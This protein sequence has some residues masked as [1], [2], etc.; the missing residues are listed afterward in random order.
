MSTCRI[1]GSTSVSGGHPFR[2]YTDFSTTLYDCNDCGCRFANRDEFIYERLHNTPS[3]YA[4]HRNL[5]VQAKSFFDR[6]D[7][8]GLSRYLRK[9]E[10]NRFILEHLE[11]AQNCNRVLEFGCSRGYLS[12]YAILLGKAFYGIDVSETALAAARADFGEY[13]HP[14]SKVDSFPDGYF[15]FIYHVGTIGCVNDPIGF[16]KRQIRLL[17][18]GGILLFNAPNLD[19]CHALGLEWLPGTTP[20]DL[21]TLFPSGF[22]THQFSDQADVS[23]R[24]GFDSPLASFRGRM[25]LAHFDFSSRGVSLF[26]AGASAV[27]ISP[28]KR[29]LHLAVHAFGKLLPPWGPFRPLP[30]QFGVYVRIQVRTVNQ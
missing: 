5:S 7:A 13:F 15:D 18:P 11:T 27:R 1:C 17:R 3:T 28:V 24:V 6:R 25:R 30:Q 12:S 22:W 26:N 9:T 2:P 10:K 14:E 19:A 21:V 20:P 29:T 8:Y 16:I 23:V 4:A